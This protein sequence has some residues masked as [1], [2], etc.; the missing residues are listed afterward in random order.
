MF[1]SLE[2]KSLVELEE[3]ILNFWNEEEIFRKSLDKRKKNPIFSF[4]DGPPFATGLPHYGHLLASTI[5]DT[6]ARYKTMQG[7]YVPRRFGWDCHGLPVENEIEKMHDLQGAHSIQE[8]GVER[9]NEECRKIVFRFS[10]EW[11][12]TINRLGRWVDFEQTYHTMDLNYMESV[13]WVFS[14]LYKKGLVYKGF[15]VMPFSAKLGTP[16]SNFEANLNYKEVDDPS[17]VVRFPLK[18]DSSTHL[19]VW[20][21]TPWTLVSNLAVAV[22]K[23]V[24]YV[25]VKQRD[26]ENMFICAKKRVQQY[27]KEDEYDLIDEVRSIDLE[28][29]EYVPPFNY[30]EDQNA[31]RV[32]IGDHVSDGD[33]TGIVHTAPGFGEED[34]FVCQKAQITPVCPVDQN[35]CFTE[36]IPEY[37][38]QFV[39]EANKD[40]IKRLKE[41]KKLFH[42]ATIRHRYPF[43]WRTDTPLIYRLTSSWFVA[44]EKIKDQIIQANKKIYWMPDHIKKGRF[45]KW[46]EG[47]RDWAISRSRY[48]GTPIPI[49]E[50]SDGSR[51]VV[52][53]VKELEEFTKH[54]ASDL[55]RHF[56]DGLEF[57]DSDGKLYKRVDE[58]FDCWFESGSMP[59]AQNHYPFE[60]KDLFN[61]TFPADFI[62]EGLDQTRGWFYT[63]TVLSAALFNE[64]PFRNVIV[65]GIILAENGQKMSKR[66]KNYPEPTQVIHKF[67]SDALRLYLINSP[68]VRAEDMKF[69]E[70]GVEQILRQTLLPL[71]NAHNFFVSYV[72]IYAWNPQTDFAK[73]EKLLDRWIISLLNK[74]VN[75]IE[76]GMDQYDLNAAITPLISFIDQLTNWYIRRSR[77]RFWNSEKCK[78]R[79]QAFST[80]YTVLVE[81]CKLAAPFVPFL[82]DTIYRNLTSSTKEPTSVH[83]CDSPLFRKDWRN[84]ALEKE[85]AALQDTV[86]L[87]H[88]LRKEHKLKVRQP[89]SAL[90]IAVGESSVEVFL[91]HQVHLIKDE[92]NVKKVVFHEDERDLVTYKLIPNFR[93]LGKKVGALMKQV[94]GK[95]AEIEGNELQKFLEEEALSISIEGQEVS[96]S[97][98]D[99][100]IKREVKEGRVASNL[101]NITLALVTELTPEL[102]QE[103]NAREIVNKIQTM[104][105]EAQFEKTDRIQVSLEV[106]ENIKESFE[107]F[108]DYIENEVLATNVTFLKKVDGV[109]W[110]INGELISISIEKDPISE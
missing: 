93:V 83:M 20:T 110:D 7:Y 37:K 8:F 31:F 6:V 94:Q 77:R 41:D 43:C 17:I 54:K 104:R 64:N 34:F 14:Q 60:N 40:I 21:T 35:G 91:K 75:E 67:G 61:K 82:S 33:G 42:R 68:V 78:D 84:L 2:N 52:G 76:M 92:L 4:F 23:D 65:N 51:K 58:V 50:A 88:A 48:W 63:L 47:A 87:G 44:V 108:R 12:K 16:L 56:I 46:L 79:D 81:F 97:M 103:G 96:L 53:S 69:H 28:G 18:E 49:W 98:E 13:W 107:A 55:H 36:E 101:G 30:F 100:Q 11:K 89:L 73:P 90:H 59:Y 9:F 3:N 38:G 32:L 106:T 102:L 39:Q 66:L 15:K 24:E 62:A 45:G 5:K 27:F 57:K 29:L 22:G 95:I 72:R 109:Q 99:V 80:L 70:K 1:E 105:R 10:D 85:M 71:W 26:T 74:L 25:K 86:S 19:L